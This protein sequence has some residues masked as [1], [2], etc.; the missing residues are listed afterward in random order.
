MGFYLEKWLRARSGLRHVG[1]DDERKGYVGY[2]F[3]YCC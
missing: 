2:E 3:C 1:E